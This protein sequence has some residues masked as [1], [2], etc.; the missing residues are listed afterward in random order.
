MPPAPWIQPRQHVAEGR[1]PSGNLHGRLGSVESTL[2][3][4]RPPQRPN[5]NAGTEPTTRT[6]LVPP[7]SGPSAHRGEPSSGVR[8]GT[9]P[10]LEV[11]RSLEDFLSSPRLEDARLANDNVEMSDSDSGSSASTH[12][13]PHPKLAALETLLEKERG[14]NARLRQQLDEAHAWGSTG[15]SE[16]I[17]ELRREVWEITRENVKLTKA[18]QAVPLA[19]SSPAVA[20][21]GLV[22]CSSHSSIDLHQY[23]FSHAPSEM[24]SAPRDSVS[25]M[26][27]MNTMNTA[28]GLNFIDLLT[29]SMKDPMKVPADRDDGSSA[30][31]ESLRS[32]IEVLEQELML[33]SR[34]EGA[35]P[36]MSFGR[37]T[38]SEEFRP[39]IA[40]QSLLRRT[41]SL[42]ILHERVRTTLNPAIPDPPT[43]SA[44]ATE[45]E[46]TH[47]PRRSQAEEAR[48]ALEVKNPRMRK[49]S[50]VGDR[51]SVV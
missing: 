41:S 18:L 31:V 1:A 27:S 51:K 12:S 23:R 49:R 46:L 25:T 43:W 24:L 30:L 7:V 44:I 50:P 11:L 26:G 38:D 20:S 21:S 36:S 35:R 42:G 29:E 4:Q 2:P 40:S 9:R 33:K 5:I 16:E 47:H 6:T 34:M 32:K 39:P 13:D 15:G 10:S 28:S 45:E 3:G 19:K 8:D 22:P 14:K 37:S 17:A 48:A